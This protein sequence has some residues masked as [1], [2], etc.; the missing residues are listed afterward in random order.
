M[1]LVG[2]TYRITIPGGAEEV[3]RSRLFFASRDFPEYGICLFGRSDE[4]GKSWK[5]GRG[6][7]VFLEMNR[8]NS[9]LN[10]FLLTPGV[11]KIA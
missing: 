11:F 10:K 6:F 9:G 5:S 1:P 7:C 8:T 2:K 4:M 3:N